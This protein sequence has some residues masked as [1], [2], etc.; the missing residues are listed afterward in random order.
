MSPGPVKCGANL[1]KGGECDQDAAVI[2]AKYIY[3]RHPSGGYDLSLTEIHYTAI[4]PSCGERKLIH[5]AEQ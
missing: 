1:T 5:K 4:C 3:D 2:K